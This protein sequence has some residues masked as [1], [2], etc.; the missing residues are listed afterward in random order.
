M[1]ISLYFPNKDDIFQK[2]MNIK[3]RTN[4]IKI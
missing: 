1:N 3:M 4:E 2:V